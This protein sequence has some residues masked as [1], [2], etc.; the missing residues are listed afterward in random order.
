[1]PEDNDFQ[2]FEV[3]RP[4]AQESDLEKAGAVPSSRMKQTRS[5]LRCLFYAPASICFESPS[6]PPGAF[7]VAQSQK[8]S[9]AQV[10]VVSPF[11]E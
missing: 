7:V 10:G 6:S 11:D 8:L 9:V 5:L 2:L 4:N 3:V 1:M